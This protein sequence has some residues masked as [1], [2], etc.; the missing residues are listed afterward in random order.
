MVLVFRKLV[1]KILIANI[2]L[3]S[4]ANENDRPLKSNPRKA[5]PSH[6]RRK[7]K[8]SIWH[9]ILIAITCFVTNHPN[10]T[11]LCAML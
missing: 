1:A 6:P 4:E 10:I 7:N 3:S 8:C 2:A 11:F 9:K 5:I